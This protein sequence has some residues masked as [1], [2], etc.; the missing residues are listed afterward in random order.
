MVYPLQYKVEHC[1]RIIKLGKEGKLPIEWAADIGISKQSLATWKTK[2]EEFGEAYAIAFTACEV[3][4]ARKGVDAKEQVSLNSAKWA[5]SAYFRVSETNKQ[6]V[7]KDITAKVIQTFPDFKD[8]D[9]LVDE[10]IDDGE[11]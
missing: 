11:V 1:E 8:R 2:Y 10:E 7:V 3:K 9:D 5:L 6:E 4:L